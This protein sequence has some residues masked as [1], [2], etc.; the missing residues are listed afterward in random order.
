[1]GGGLDAVTAAGRVVV[2]H[3]GFNLRFLPSWRFTRKGTRS[4]PEPLHLRLLEHIQQQPLYPLRRATPTSFPMLGRMTSIPVTD[5]IVAPF[6]DQLQALPDLRAEEP[7]D[8]YALKLNH[9]T[10]LGQFIRLWVGPHDV[11]VERMLGKDQWI[12][13]SVASLTELLLCSLEEATLDKP[14]TIPDGMLPTW[15]VDA[16]V[17]RHRHSVV[18]GMK[19][20]RRLLDEVIDLGERSQD[21]SA[22][23]GVVAHHAARLAREAE[24]RNALARLR[25]GDLY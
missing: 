5:P 14:E 2:G 1:M 16:H 8:G 6:V 10:G 9:F 7:R 18:E 17:N 11:I 24:T 19:A 4:A 23:A 15:Q 20:L 3:E 13:G 21:M 25:S 22:Q 12:P